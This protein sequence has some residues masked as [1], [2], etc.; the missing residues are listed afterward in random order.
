LL[1]D[2]ST[3]LLLSDDEEDNDSDEDEEPLFTEQNFMDLQKKEKPSGSTD[4]IEKR[5]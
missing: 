3:P 2:I 5:Y 4:I 1:K